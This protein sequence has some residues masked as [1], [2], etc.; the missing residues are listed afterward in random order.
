MRVT[1]PCVLRAALFQP[2]VLRTAMFWPHIL[3]TVYQQN[4]HF[5]QFHLHKEDTMT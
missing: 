1:P 5:W 2:L 3:R 4:N